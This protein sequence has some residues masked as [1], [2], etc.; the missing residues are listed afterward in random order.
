MSK[1]YSLDRTTE[2]KFSI[3]FIPVASSKSHQG[4]LRII[5]VDGRELVLTNRVRDFSA[6]AAQFAQR[7]TAVQLVPCATYVL[8]GGSLD[9]D[10]FRLARDGLHYKRKLIAWSDIEQITLDRAGMLKFKTPKLW[11]SPRFSTDTLPNASLLLQLA[12]MFG[13]EIVE[14]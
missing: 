2:T 12:A 1:L 5:L 11:R 13:G 10:K 3:Y 4:R 7:A 9:F 8:D 14:T 6:M